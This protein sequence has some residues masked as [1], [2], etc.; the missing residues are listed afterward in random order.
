LHARTH[1]YHNGEAALRRLVVGAS[2]TNCL[3]VAARLRRGKIKIAEP[4][5]E[6]RRTEFSATR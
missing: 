4:V 3:T 6:L 5:N 2:E 1:H